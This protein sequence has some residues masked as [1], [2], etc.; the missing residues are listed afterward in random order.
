MRKSLKQ[1]V[2]N[3]A[4]DFFVEQNATSKRITTEQYLN[5]LQ[6]LECKRILE[7]KQKEDEEAKV[8]PFYI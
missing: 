5:E 6:M 4:N 2:L 7:K 8:N 1:K 3:K